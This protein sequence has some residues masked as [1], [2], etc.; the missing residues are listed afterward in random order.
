MLLTRLAR[1]AEPFSLKE[2]ELQST[3]ITLSKED[4]I[5][6]VWTH[7]YLTCDFVYNYHTQPLGGASEYH[8]ITRGGVKVGFIGIVENW[9]KKSVPSELGGKYQDFVEV[10]PAF[11]CVQLTESCAKRD[12]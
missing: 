4:C 5:C 12:H 9:I 11:L 8:T 6:A 1:C 7:L 3:R 10:V 2:L